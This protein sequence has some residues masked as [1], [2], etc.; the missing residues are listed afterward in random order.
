MERTSQREA[1]ERRASAAWRGVGIG[2][3]GVLVMGALVVGVAIGTSAPARAHGRWLLGA[4]HHRFGGHD[5]ERVRAHA[6]LATRWVTRAIDA[7]DEQEE[8]VQAIVAATASELLELAPRHRE[9][10]E[11]FV[12]LLAGEAIDRGALESLRAE[13]IALLEAASRRLVSAL[14]DVAE[15]LTPEQRAELA[16][17]HRALR[18]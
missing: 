12:A 11:R 16:S 3:A 18:H 7:T 15:V 10:R 2:I 17:L 13:E 1:G 6:E 14:A 8:R 9:H 5:P 4:G